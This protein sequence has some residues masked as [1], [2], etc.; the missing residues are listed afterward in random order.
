MLVRV[1]LEKVEHGSLDIRVHGVAGSPFLFLF[2]DGWSLC[3]DR[4]SHNINM[5]VEAKNRKCLLFKWFA[6]EKLDE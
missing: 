5:T 3:F 2:D 4:Q 1:V 6:A